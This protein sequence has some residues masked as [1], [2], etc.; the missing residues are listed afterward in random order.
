M[1]IIFVR[2][3][4]QALIVLNLISKNFISK[5]FIFVKAHQNDINEDAIEL[6]YFYKKIEKKAIYTTHLV[7][8]NGLIKS[9]ISI[10]LLSILAFISCGKF[11]LTAIST[12]VFSIVAKLNPLLKIVTFDDGMA[13]I[14]KE[15]ENPY[16]SNKALAAS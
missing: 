15:S 9:V 1:D 16:F 4:L 7:E 3:K 5:N 2:T 11:Y 8:K 14:Y 10:Y 6:D 12:Y 13:N